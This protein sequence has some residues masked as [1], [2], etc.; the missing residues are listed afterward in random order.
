MPYAVIKNKIADILP[1]YQGELLEF[2]D[3]LRFKQAGAQ[4]MQSRSPA[5]HVDA[6]GAPRKLGGYEKGFY[7]SPDFDEPLE[8]F[9]EYM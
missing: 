6:A 2:I 7:M 4:R 9:K 1:Q 5:I 3:F 8:C